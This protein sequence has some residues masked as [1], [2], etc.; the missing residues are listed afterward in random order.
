VSQRLIL[1]PED[2]AESREATFA[3]SAFT[4]RTDIDEPSKAIGIGAQTY[5]RLD[6]PNPWSIP[7]GSRCVMG[8]THRLLI[9]L[10]IG[11]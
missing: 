7:G 11:A 8:N 4:P 3:L 5:V 9:G 6:R 1:L 2:E 10:A